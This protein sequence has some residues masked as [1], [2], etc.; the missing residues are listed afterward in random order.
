ME[1][2]GFDGQ[3][4]HL[5][6]GQETAVLLKR[7]LERWDAFFK[8]PNGI[9]LKREAVERPNRKRERAISPWR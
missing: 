8:G 6:I 9:L 2:F 7:E 1:P 3:R 4:G 5:S